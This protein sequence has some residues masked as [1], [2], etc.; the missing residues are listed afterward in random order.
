MR[1]L[2]L[3]NDHICILITEVEGALHTVVGVGGQTGLT[4][5]ATLA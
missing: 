5:K 1:M 4:A 2:C 3:M